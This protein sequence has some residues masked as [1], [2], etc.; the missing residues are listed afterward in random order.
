MSNR[1]DIEVYDA[2][3]TTRL[4]TLKLSGA[5]I[6]SATSDTV[7]MVKNASTSKNAA[8]VLLGA[9]RADYL[10]SAPAGEDTDTT[11]ERGGELVA[12]QWIEARLLATDAWAQVG[13]MP[14]DSF[15]VGA[16]AAGASKSVRLRLNIPADAATSFDVY[17][18]LAFRVEAA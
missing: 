9:I 18:S 2:A 12:E 14:A 17:F 6:G 16:L 15:D 10:L 8:H 5:Q 3:G 13:E 11:N 1:I 4:S 7:I